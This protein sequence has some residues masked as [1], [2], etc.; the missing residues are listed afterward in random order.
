MSQ[1]DV[2][3]SH[4]K[5]K[6]PKKVRVVFRTFVLNGI[7]AASLLFD[8][9]GRLVKD[10]VVGLGPKRY[11]SWEADFLD[12]AVKKYW[13]IYFPEKLLGSCPTGFGKHD[14]DDV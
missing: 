9:E 14:W 10:A 1:Q 6:I 2:K 11:T 12:L 8:E 4:K 13:E 5:R 3:T 7:R